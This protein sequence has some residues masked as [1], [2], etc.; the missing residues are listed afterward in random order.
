M[1]IVFILVEP[2]VEENI[3]AAARALNTMGFGRL[4]L[5]NPR[6]DHLGERSKMM[7]HGSHEVLDQAEIFEDFNEA[8]MDMDLV[9]GTSSK[10]RKTHVDR[11]EGHLLPEIMSVK[12]EFVNQAAVVFGCEESGLNNDQLKACDIISYIPLKESYPSLNLSQAVMLYAYILSPLKSGESIIKRPAGSENIRNLKKKLELIL[13][14]IDI[15]NKEI[16]GPRIM[17]RITFLDHDDL[18]LVQSVCNA[19][20]S[21]PRFQNKET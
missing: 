17:E 5:V 13:E 11:V 15:T 7:A 1:E 20:L 4:R 14:L 10:R 6:A 2:A 8:I 12:N 9:V 3:G 19:F 16:I 21:G 18:Q